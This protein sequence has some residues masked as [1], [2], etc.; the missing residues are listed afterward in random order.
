MI[1]PRH[2]E[3]AAVVGTDRLSHQLPDNRAYGQAGRHLQNIRDG[4]SAGAA[5]D[6]FRRFQHSRLV[7]S[8][9]RLL[10]ALDEDSTSF[11]VTADVDEDTLLFLSRKDAP[12]GKFMRMDISSLPKTSLS[13]HI[14][15]QEN[16]FASDFYGDPTFIV[17]GERIYAKTLSG[18]PQ[19]LEV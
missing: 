8:E 13:P 16:S 12:R 1:E 4:W 17:H 14:G 19:E 11:A 5:K 7:T 9:T 18:G 6:R 2:R 15:Q 3:I 10:R